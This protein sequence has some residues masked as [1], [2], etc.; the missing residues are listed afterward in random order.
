MSRGGSSK[1]SL[2]AFDS[3]NGAAD[4]RTLRRH[5]RRLVGGCLR[6]SQPTEARQER[7]GREAEWAG[8]FWR[9]RRMINFVSFEKNYSVFASHEMS[10]S[11]RFLRRQERISLWIS[12]RIQ[13][14][15]KRPVHASRRLQRL[16]Q[17]ARLLQIIGNFPIF[18]ATVT[19]GCSRFAAS[20]KEQY[21]PW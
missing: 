15:R 13:R 16:L 14:R 7:R 19:T 1:G 12:C 17:R 20:F 21:R 5:N 4:R 18:T 3:K 11:F 9:R 10:H 8:R 6:C 2:R